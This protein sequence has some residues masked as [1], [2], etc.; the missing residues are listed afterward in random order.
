MSIL[1]K[2]SKKN[3]S[4]IFSNSKY[5]LLS[6]IRTIRKKLTS[7]YL[8]R[9]LKLLINRICILNKIKNPDFFYWIGNRSKKNQK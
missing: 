9:K 6:S 2:I 3:L 4:A 7:Q 1:F 5:R 8:L